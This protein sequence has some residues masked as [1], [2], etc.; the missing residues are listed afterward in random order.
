MIGPGLDRL[1]RRHH[2]LLI[3]GLGPGG[4]HAGR[5]QQHFRANQRADRRE[6]QRRENQPVDAKLP[7]L[8]RPKRRQLRHAERIAGL[9]QIGVVVRGHHRDGQ[10]PQTVVARAGAGR[11]HCLRKAV[12]R[13]KIDAELRDLPS[14]ALHRGADVV[15]LKIKENALVRLFQ[16]AG[17]TEPAGVGELQSYFVKGH[18]VAELRNQGSRGLDALHVERDDQPVARLRFASRHLADPPERPARR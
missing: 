4:A 2:A 3:V 17:E 15:Q 10:Q 18:A 16:L 13:Q 14:R 9:A 1:P 12:D 8:R 5:D 7:R 11:A 6:L